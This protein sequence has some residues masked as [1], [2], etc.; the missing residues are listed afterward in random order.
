MWGL[1]IRN[2]T[3][4][5][6][7]IA[8]TID[9]CGTWLLVMAVPTHI[10]A[11]T[12]SAVSTAL[13][14]AVEALPAVV[15]G[16][17][18]GTAADR[19]PPRAVLATGNLVAALGVCLLL[20]GPTTIYLA[21]LVES[22]AVCFLRPALQATIP[23]LTATTSDRATANALLALS[24]S[25]LRIGAPLAGAALTAAGWFPAVVIADALSYLAAATLL[26][27]LTLPPAADP[28]AR[29]SAADPAARPS[30]ADAA[31]RS[32]VVD[33][34][35]RSSVVDS[36]ARSSAADPAARRPAA[37]PAARRSVAD[38]AA[39][40]LVADST[41][42]RSVADPINRRPAA[43]TT[44]WASRVR[45]R[46][47]RFVARALPGRACEGRSVGRASGELVRGWRLVSRSRVLVGLLVGSW[48]YWT[49]NAGLT[50]L[51]VPFVVQRLHSSGAAVGYLI[52]GLGV[53]YLAGALVSRAVLLRWPA[54]RQLG[55][56]YALVALCFLVMFT[57]GSLPVAVAAV[58]VAGV[59]GA[60]ANVATGHHVQSFA[61]PAALGRVAAVFMTSDAVAAVAGALAALVFVVVT[62]LLVTLTILSGMVMLAALVAAVLLPTGRTDPAVSVAASG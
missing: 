61:P 46:L 35:A 41:T 30:V 31:A 55:V 42:R 27:R 5:R 57:A 45:M 59:P 37:D 18:A 8:A 52:T 24:H 34:A 12:G 9:A 54:R 48:L 29:S 47:W 15:L 4:R 19:W 17:W 16:P 2:W 14:L 6:L 38:P 28:A 21:L 39:R 10:Y 43:D 44:V 7:W 23:A 13:A 50:A 20:I 22:I 62:G 36:A 33:S 32:S 49:A 53:G 56:S 51:L 58:T 25:A 26:A 60:V 3:F 11:V 40:R 1:L